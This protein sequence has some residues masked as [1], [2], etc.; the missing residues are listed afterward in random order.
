MST[1]EMMFT[2]VQT[3]LADFAGLVVRAETSEVYEV[4]PSKGRSLVVLPTDRKVEDMTEKLAMREQYLYDLEEARG[5]GPRRI[6]AKHVA[7][8]LDGF[9]DYVN[10]HKGST[11]AISA[12][13]GLAPKLVATIDFHGE[14]DGETGP[15]PRWGK[16]TVEYAFPFANVFRQWQNA[17]T[18]QDKKRFLDWVETHAVELAHPGE[19]TE[20]GKLTSDIFNK[21]LIVRGKDK[22]AR[23]KSFADTG[24]GAVFGSASELFNGAKLMNGSTAEK[25]EEVVDDMGQVAISYT[26][27]D[28]VEGA[29]AKRYYL[30]DIK[31]FDGDEEPRCVPVRLDLAV[32]GG[33]L[34]LSLHLIGVEQ[35][36]EASFL[37]AC[38]KV[39]EATKVAPIRAV[40]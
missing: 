37:E 36:V 28:R 20:A 16:H 24:L 17:A 14:S 5:E 29:T 32:D 39:K 11:T 18:W 21:V 38:A 13:G 33:K 8:T 30:A 12:R 2:K 15:D 34:G 27:S 22:V 9:V 26:R 6:A 7:E 10:R 25:L 31:V 19:I 23:E 35:I 4:E 3:L 40:F 1:I